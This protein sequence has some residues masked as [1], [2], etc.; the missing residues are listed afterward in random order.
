MFDVIFVFL[1]VILY[2]LDV[3]RHSDLRIFIVVHGRL[4]IIIVYD[5]T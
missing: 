1:L 2:L 4:R 5:V 3:Y